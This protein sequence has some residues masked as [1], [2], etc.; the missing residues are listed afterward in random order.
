MNNNPTGKNL[1]N[2]QLQIKRLNNIG[3][4]RQPAAQRNRMDHQVV[5]IDKPRPYKTAH[6]S[7]SAKCDNGFARLLL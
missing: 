1:R 5:F 7:G 6:K 3:K 4:D 2:Y